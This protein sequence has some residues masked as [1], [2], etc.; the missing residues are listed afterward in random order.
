MFCS[1]IIAT[2]G[3]DTL[4]RAVESVLAQ[5]LNAVAFEVIV[6]NDS[7]VPLPEAAWQRS[8]RV[9]IVSTNR[10]ERSVARNVGAAM[11]NGA[12]LHFLDDDD[13][14]APDALAQFWNA[15]EKGAWLYGVSQLVDR[16]DR[17]L[18]ELRH[19][20]EGNCLLPVMAGEWIPLQAS[21]IGSRLFFDVGGFNP[22]LVGPEDVDLL[23]RLA[24]RYELVSV[25]AVV[26]FVEMGE[27]GSTT[28]YEQ[29]ARQSRR[30]REGVLDDG[31]TFGRLRAG[32]VDAYWSGRLVRVYL[33]SVVWNARRLRLLTALGR[34]TVALRGCAAAGRALV[35]PAF[36]ASVGRPYA[37]ETFARGFRAQR[38]AAQ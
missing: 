19:G 38:Q 35:A 25:P 14:L 16:Q 33:T 26:A 37:S 34:A 5:T 30:A 6:V 28:D 36:W 32:A 22:L 10:R 23:R 11:A 31:A 17:P 9:R 24:L 8:E 7:G 21:L 18:V 29:H 12:Y 27:E 3:R 1:T 13:W 15:R 20:L 2:V 4:A